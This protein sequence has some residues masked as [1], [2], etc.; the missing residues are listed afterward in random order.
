MPTYN[1]CGQLTF[2]GRCD[3]AQ[4]VDGPYLHLG[5]DSD[6]YP[7]SDAQSGLAR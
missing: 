2:V 1:D 5:S 6:V 4:E 7:S 3:V